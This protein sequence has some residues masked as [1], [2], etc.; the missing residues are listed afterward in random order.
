MLEYEDEYVQLTKRSSFSHNGEFIGIPLTKGKVAIIDIEDY[1]LIAYNWCIGDEVKSKNSL[2]YVKKHE[3]KTTVS[4]HRV[5]MERVLGRP[6][7]PGEHIDHIDHDG[8]NNRRSNLRLAS[9]G[10]NSKNQRK[11]STRNGKP[12]SSLY[13][14][15][16]FEHRSK[17]HPWLANIGINGKQKYLGCFATEEEA[18]KAYDRAA[19]AHFGAFAYT[20]FPKESYEEGIT[21]SSS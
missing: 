2:Y 17:I 9:Q 8:L 14:G 12:T 13:K 19:I 6:L 10:D 5:I 18:A 4:M 16:S 15:V 21:V 3:G 1:D 20:N 11:Q 7:E